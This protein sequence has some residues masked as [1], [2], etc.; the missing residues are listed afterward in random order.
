[1]KE[2]RPGLSASSL[3]VRAGTKIPRF[4]RGD[5]F[6]V[7]DDSAVAWAENPVVGDHTCACEIGFSIA[8]GA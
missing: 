6:L 2:K 8:N 7:R 5:N 3:V 4:A 1:V